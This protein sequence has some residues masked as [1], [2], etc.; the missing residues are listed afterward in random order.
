MAS[1]K[2]SL[3]QP[4]DCAETSRHPRRSRASK[5]GGPAKQDA[6]ES[7]LSS[8]P[9]NIQQIKSL[10]S[11][12]KQS[13]RNQEPWSATIEYQRQCL[14]QQYL[15]LIFHSCET[16]KSDPAGRNSYSEEA[17]NLLWLDTSYSLIN[18]YRAKLS[19]M[20]QEIERPT[21]TGHKKSGPK[22]QKF[23]SDRSRG[24]L[25]NV[26]PVARRK[27]LQHFRSFL[28]TE[29]GFWKSLIYRLVNDHDIEAAKGCLKIL[30]IF[31]NRP[32]NEEPRQLDPSDQ[33]DST[34][35]N[36]SEF[37]DEG[38][39]LVHKALICFGDLIRYGELYAR[40]GGQTS[41][42]SGP[43]NQS[44]DKA[45][46]NLAVER[47]WSRPQDCYNQARL[48]IPTNGNPSNQLAVLSSYIP[49]VLSCAYHYYRALCIKRP[50]PT[51]RQ[52]LRSTFTKALAKATQADHSLHSPGPHELFPGDLKLN[53]DHLVSE[54][55]SR[56]VVLHAS[57]YTRAPNPFTEC[58]V[59]LCR[60]FAN[61]L[62]DRLLPPELI[63]KMIA[64]CMAAAWYARVDAG[65]ASTH[66]RNGDHIDS[67][68]RP[69]SHS[70]TTEVN[71]IVHFLQ[72]SAALLTVAKD[73][74]SSIDESTAHA[75]LS[76]SIPAVLRRILPAMRIIS[77][78][79]LSGH[80]D[81]IN[82]VKLRLARSKKL[83]L[84][85]QLVTAE[86]E[87]WTQYHQA[88]ELAKQHFPLD[89]LQ[90][91][92]D[93][94]RLEEDLE[95]AGFLPIEKAMKIHQS[96]SSKPFDQVA[97]PPACGACHPNEEHLMRMADL[98]RD[99]NQ[100]DAKHYATQSN[101]A[102]PKNP[103]EI[104]IGPNEIENLQKT[105]FANSSS[106]SAPSKAA[107]NDPVN[108]IHGLSDEYGNWTDDEDPVELA[109]RA[110][111][112]QQMGNEQ[113]SSSH[114]TLMLQTLNYSGDVT[115]DDEVDDDDEDVILYLTNPSGGAADRPESSGSTLEMSATLQFPSSLYQTPLD[116]VGTG[117]RTAADLLASM[118]S[119]PMATP[120]H[121]HQPN[122][123]VPP[124]VPAE[125]WNPFSLAGQTT[126]GP[127]LRTSAVAHPPRH[128][129]RVPSVSLPKPA[130]ASPKINIWSTLPASS[131]SSPTEANMIMANDWPASTAF[132]G[133][134]D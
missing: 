13:I 16:L 40:T 4:K 79:V 64:I 91:L 62:K 60:E 80:F 81:H 98:Q 18:I 117:M 29:D 22:N 94:S 77:K 54:I 20:D 10:S 96:T 17:L 127:P 27:L 125:R 7:D 45:G 90:A 12:L 109:M 46:K 63:L 47:D 130:E 48:L 56:F 92:D 106:P 101:L 104:A 58:N 128:G 21:H 31:N 6:N 66:P 55:R 33:E 68:S 19:T 115:D 52:N 25:P 131:S 119:T 85:S 24:S 69:A 103:S 82:R 71:A 89:K 93:S 134:L 111:V 36:L 83:K 113:T 86:A 123:V 8:Q 49:D 116:Q 35:N 74:L 57:L 50:F 102:E 28:R 59:K 51:A 84:N 122:A 124:P 105:D 73:E 76:Q 70:Y 88:I 3:N 41:P 120:H 67:R 61:H 100:I 78:W 11:T 132:L 9:A 14:R 133:Q 129:G 23:Q 38:I 118:I 44:R 72:F 30:K 112:A 34:N 42:F 108:T 26:G 97:L 95:L 1:R 5:Q 15:A 110:V 65:S 39:P 99:A 126:P 107:Q 53:P 37:K 114:N 32:R 87:F 43:T 2:P 75:D 121:S